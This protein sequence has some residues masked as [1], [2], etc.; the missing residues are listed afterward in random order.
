M[1]SIEVE[2]KL[3]V[4]SDAIPAVRQQLFQFPHTYI[5]P[6]HLT[7]IYFETPDNQLR[8]WDMGLRIRG[9]D[10]HYEMT[11]KTAGQVIGGLHQ[12]PEFNV[13]LQHPKLDLAQFPSHI[14]PEN[15]DLALLQSQL[16]ELFSTDFTREKWLVTYGKSEIGGQSKIEVVLDQ[17]CVSAENTCSETQTSPI[18]EFELELQNGHVT[19]I[20]SLADQLASLNGLRLA[21]KS[22]AARGYA[23]AY[24]SPR[25]ALPSVPDKLEW[26]QP[27]SVLL[28][29]ILAQWQEQEEGWLSG[30]AE[31]QTGLVQVLHWVTQLTEKQAERLPE[32]GLLSDLLPT[33]KDALSTVGAEAETLCY[34]SAWLQCKLALTRW[35]IAQSR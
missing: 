31:G 10:G 6:Q 24:G 2:L 9:F 32:F 35:L 21:N 1:R 12:R 25:N 14:W 28:T 27:L 26:Q 33:L 34:S 3:S 16:T 30:L 15:T 23:L 19:D 8:R 11:I 5:S 29:Q 20:L 13:P 7:N 22:K 4:K 18:C 17:G